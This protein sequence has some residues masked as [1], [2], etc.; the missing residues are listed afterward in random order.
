MRR[1]TAV[2]LLALSILTATPTYAAA[3]A[4]RSFIARVRHA[5][6]RFLGH[7]TSNEDNISPPKP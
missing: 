7:T 3:S 2:L 5:I 1:N 6:A 4:D